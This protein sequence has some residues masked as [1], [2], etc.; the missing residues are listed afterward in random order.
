[1]DGEA[2]GGN[3]SLPRRNA[4]SEREE[5][6]RIERKSGTLGDVKQKKAQRRD[7]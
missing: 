1:M 3:G 7:N 4:G 2:Y 5:E 6:G